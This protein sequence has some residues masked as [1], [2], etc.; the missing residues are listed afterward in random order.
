MNN[1]KIYANFTVRLLAH[2]IDIIFLL[3]I[4]FLISTI[5]NPLPEVHS[6]IF[7]ELS[8]LIISAL[9]YTI[10]TASN[11]YT[12]IGK[13]L[14]GIMVVDKKMQAL[15]LKHSFARYLAYYFSYI[16]L[17]IGFLMILMTRKNKALHDKIANTYVIYKR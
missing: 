13:E 12:T 6:S 17:G 15:S 1:Q 9:Y 8:Y 2:I 5:F 4:V 11:K 10:C 14:M 7:R 3:V 16:T